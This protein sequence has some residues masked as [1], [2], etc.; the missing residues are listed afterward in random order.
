MR[1]VA[2]GIVAAENLKMP[3]AKSQLANKFAVI[4]ARGAL[5][6]ERPIAG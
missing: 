1:R 4:E 3:L 5:L 6:F 2:R